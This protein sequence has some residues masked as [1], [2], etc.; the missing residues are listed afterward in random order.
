MG[1]QG[2]G[3]YQKVLSHMPQRFN[4]LQ[5]LL[6]PSMLQQGVGTDHHCKLILHMQDASASDFI[7]IALR[8]KNTH[9]DIWSIIQK[10]KILFT[11]CKS[12]WRKLSKGDTWNVHLL[13]TFSIYRQTPP[14]CDGC[15]S[16]MCGNYETKTKM[17]GNKDSKEIKNMMLNLRI[18]KRNLIAKIKMCKNCGE[19]IQFQLQAW[20]SQFILLCFHN[21]VK[22][23]D[24]IHLNANA[25]WSRSLAIVFMSWLLSTQ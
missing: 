8:H 14:E 6:L 16:Q 2:A 4:G 12:R 13:L 23:V 22:S 1:S 15:A 21:R 17:S 9:A 25:P 20:S 3:H 5:P 24:C 11:Y 19:L 7:N 10:L 18:Y